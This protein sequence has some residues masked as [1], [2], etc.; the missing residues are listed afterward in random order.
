VIVD[1]PEARYGSEKTGLLCGYL[2][3]PGHAGSAIDGEEA[4]AVLASHEPRDSFLWLHFNLANQMS[5]RWLKQH[6]D[7]PEEYHSLL[8]HVSSTRV[9]L[10]GNA[11]IATINDV[12]LY[13]MDASDVATMAL[14]VNHRVLVSARHAP[15]RSAERLRECVKAGETFRSAVEVLAHLLRD[16]ADVLVQIVR[17]ATAQVDRIEDKIIANHSGASRSTLGAL[18]RVLVRLQRLLA[19]EPAA[20]FRLL[21]RAP[22]W[23]TEA[24]RQDL[25]QAVEELATAVTDSSG[26]VERIRLLQEEL[27]ALL[28]EQT[29]R[30]LFVLTVVT[31]VALPMTIIPGLLGMNVGGLP[32]RDEP[33]GFWL[34]VAQTTALAV[35]SGYWLLRK[36][37]DS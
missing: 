1:A 19:P 34:I 21:N 31:V 36:R 9:E 3:A 2:F 12:T 33:W 20:L 37:G 28:N 14:Y 6:L 18:R 5:V 22:A 13:G 32:L 27:L 4:A 16:Q 35:G 30:T 10:V 8:D 7:L 29:N 24:D 11:L 17:D 25:R 15:L 23:I 26:L